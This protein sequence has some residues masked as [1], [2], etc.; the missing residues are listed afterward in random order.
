MLRTKLFKGFVLIVVIFSLLSAYVGIWTIRRRVI[1]EAQTRVSLDLGSAW[2]IYNN[3]LHEVEIVLRLA[4]L[5]EAVVTMCEAQNWS[6][7][8]VGNRLTRIRQTFGLDFLDV[9]GPDG[10]VVMRTAAP[11]ATGDFKTAD[12]AVAS[13]LR[14]EPL[15]CMRLVPRGELESEADGLTDKAFVE[16][17]DTPHARK[18]PRAVEDRGMAMTGAVP[19]RQGAQVLGVIYGGVLVNRNSELVDRIHNVVFKNE[20]YRGVPVGTATIFLGDCRVATTVRLK[21]GNRAIGTRASKEVADRV[22]DNGKPWVGDAFVVSDWYL[23][24]YE[25]IKDGEGQVIGMLYVGALKKPFEDAGRSMILQYVYVSLFVLGVSLVL[26]FIIAGRLA[27][28]IHRLVEASN[29]LT[30]GGRHAAVPEDSSCHETALLTKAFNQMTATLAEREEHLKALNRSYME[31]LGFVSHELKSPVATI[32]NYTYLMKE[33][34]LGD[35]TE[36]QQKAMRAIDSASNRLVEMV[37]HYLNLARIENREFAPVRTRVAV[38][39]EVIT[40]LME[41]CDGQLQAAGKR[42]DCEVG[43]DVVLHADINMVREVFENLVSNAI[44]YGRSGGRIWLRSR[45]DGAFVE[46][47]VKNEGEGIPEDKHDEIFQKFTRLDGSETV[48]RQKGTGLGLFITR[49]I[50][51]AH[52]GRIGVSSRHGEWTQ[53]TFT[54]P[55]LADPGGREGDAEEEGPRN[56]SRGA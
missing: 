43:A 16:V 10:R 8:D 6:D 25:P 21:N 7:A 35:L 53:F 54:L 2:A 31:T 15:V 52:G 23:A 49:T 42:V 48:K 9:I 5:K 55:A 37:R 27:M 46:F 44:K 28:P 12:P 11:Y 41:A 3:Q 20:K 39:E 56:G 32:M 50:V 33:R 47:V 18:S 30:N 51:E 14:G 13:A 45:R 29:R 24:A 4:A 19:V 26:A 38:T 1:D 22:L 40:P 36:K 17:E 34:K